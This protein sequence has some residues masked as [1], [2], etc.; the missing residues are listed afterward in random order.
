[1]NSLIIVH[2]IFIILYMC[3]PHQMLATY[4]TMTKAVGGE[5]HATHGRQDSSDSCH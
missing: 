3:T 2:C 4:T 1:M 5:P